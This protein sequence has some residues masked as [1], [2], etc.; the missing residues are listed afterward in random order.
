[1]ETKRL[2]TRVEIKAVDTSQRLIT[3]HAAAIGNRDRTSDII[4]KG[5]F[6][7][8]LLEN[9]DVLVFIGH[10]ASRLPVG[11]PA[12][13]AQ[14]AKGL[15]TTTRVYN[16]P[17]G[18]ELL[19]VARQRM[20]SGK[21]LGMSI[22][23]RTVKHKYVGSVRHLQDVDLLEYSFLA[24]PNLAANPEATVTAVKSHN[25]GPELHDGPFVGTTCVC[26]ECKA[27]YIEHQADIASLFAPA[28]AAA[29]SDEQRST[30]T[31]DLHSLPDAAFAF[32]EPGGAKDDEQKTVPRATRHFAHHTPDGSLDE[33]LLATALQEAGSSEHGERALAHLK[34]H[35]MKSGLG[36]WPHDGT[37]D[38]HSEQWSRG[39]APIILVAAAK[40][41]AL[42]EDIAADELAM[43]RLGLDTKN[44]D[45]LNATILARLGELHTAIGQ[46]KQWAESIEHGE[47][48]KMRV[49][50]F[51]HKLAMLELSEVS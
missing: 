30:A 29:K 35:A 33:G 9:P 39:A 23:Y 11:E 28:G 41:V 14:D 21:T 32:I 44:G 48:G 51:R 10:D 37:D 20:A 45:R 27:F 42:A 18:D 3:G 8:T 34:R 17:A 43:K 2:Y 38:A 24:S 25:A 5:A 31:V 46:I 15:L 22:G 13:M 16:T 40:M 26:D 1:M 4:D 49:D 6:D 19:E 50:L 12:S 7:R 47:D 36:F